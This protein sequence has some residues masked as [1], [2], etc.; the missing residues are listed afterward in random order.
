MSN[1]IQETSETSVAISLVELARME[2]ERVRE[3]DT[4][5]A[6]AREQSA[7]D[8][9]EEDRRRRAEE[10][11]RIAAQEEA[12]AARQREEAEM[13][14]RARAREQAA[15]EVA[16]IEAA[17]RARLE[18][19]NAARAHELEVL[20]VK[21][22]SG[23]RRLQIALAAAV[24]LALTIGPAAAYTAHRKLSDL[25][26]QTAQ[27]RETHA[28]LS[29]EHDQARTTEL[30]SLDRRFA[31]LAVK[32]T[33]VADPRATEEARATAE[34][35]RKAIDAKALDHNRLRAFGDAVD[36]LEA[37]IEVVERLA[38][39]E[40]RHAD[41]DAWAGQRKKADVTAGARTAA[42]RAK[43]HS[44]GGALRAY[45]VALDDLRDAL[46]RDGLRGGAAAS[47]SSS[48]SS[49][50]ST[51]IGMGKCTDPHDP[52]CGLGGR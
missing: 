5:R 28:A 31:A 18:S 15:L 33:A 16:R 21:Q 46:A 47:T 38:S 40:R 7:R 3:E 42:A 45:E 22:Q 30:A 2:Q 13:Q 50:S 44:D 41:L 17:G 43:A 36:A 14:T 32:S 8:R 23:R 34:A 10:E 27:L 20:R 11:R 19:E 49:T 37:K 29:R 26:Q 24:G 6:R 35:A 25:E 12:R 9:Q 48:T 39:L 51:I 52:L 4:R 1:M